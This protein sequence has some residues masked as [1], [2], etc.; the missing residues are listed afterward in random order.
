LISQSQPS[1]PL[2]TLAMGAATSLVVGLF[3]LYWL[4]R[5][6]NEGWIHR[7]AWWVIPLGPA[8]VAWQLLA[9]Q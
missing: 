3:S 5:W 8:V 6:L 7:F 9:G 1:V 4:V 2:G